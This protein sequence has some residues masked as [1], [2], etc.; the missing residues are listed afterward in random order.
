[1]W[2]QSPA[3]T[4]AVA[5]AAA[6]ARR[7]PRLPDLEALPGSHGAGH[8]QGRCPPLHRLHAASSVGAEASLGSRHPRALCW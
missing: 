7:D 8:S 6:A 4:V 1:M 2:G 5:V 3:V